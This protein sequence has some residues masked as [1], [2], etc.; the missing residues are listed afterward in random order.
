VS[1]HETGTAA[2]LF[3]RTGQAAD[4]H[5]TLTTKQ[6]ACDKFQTYVVPGKPD[7]S[8]LYL[9]VLDTTDPV[10]IC[11]SRMPPSGASLPTEEV[12]AVRQ[13]ILTGANP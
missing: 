1:C 12:E 4:N 6:T 3:L 7:E 10:A 13:W 9:K 8:Y 2:G 11:G 5:L